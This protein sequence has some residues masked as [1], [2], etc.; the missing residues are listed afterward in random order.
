MRK[1]LSVNLML[2]ELGGIGIDLSSTCENRDMIERDVF[3]SGQRWRVRKSDLGSYGRSW[4]KIKVIWGTEIAVGAREKRGPGSHDICL[5]R[6][7]VVDSSATGRFSIPLIWLFCL[8]EYQQSFDINLNHFVYFYLRDASA[9][10]FFFSSLTCSLD[11]R[12]R[13]H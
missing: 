5:T 9:F 10:S 12:L 11:L 7:A 8:T 13:T 3:C 1:L 6:S 4:R 2:R